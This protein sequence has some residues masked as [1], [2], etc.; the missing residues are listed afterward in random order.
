MEGCQ[1]S[2]NHTAMQRFSL[3]TNGFTAES[4]QMLDCKV[5]DI[6]VEA[7]GLARLTS[8]HFAVRSSKLDQS[9]E[10]L[11]LIHCGAGSKAM[12]RSEP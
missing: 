3:C 10:A 5:V 4:S 6:V 1:G 7:S 9:L 8:L 11:K 2:F 12:L